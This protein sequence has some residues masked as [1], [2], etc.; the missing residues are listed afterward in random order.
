MPKIIM[1]KTM[2][3]GGRTYR[4]GDAAQL[5]RQDARVLVAIGHAKYAPADDVRKAK[6]RAPIIHRDL[7][8]PPVTTEPQEMPHPVG[9][10]EE[11]PSTPIEAVKP[12]V[13]RFGPRAGAKSSK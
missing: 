11:I 7:S 1:N 5:A 9:Q 3:L 2:H 10:V 4:T 13:S 12:Y 6:A 8:P